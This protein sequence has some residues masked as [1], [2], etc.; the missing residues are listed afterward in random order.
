[1][2]YTQLLQHG[3]DMIPPFAEMMVVRL[4]PAHDA[5]RVTDGCLEVRLAGSYTG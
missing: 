1:M 5:S 2:Q 4:P 3:A